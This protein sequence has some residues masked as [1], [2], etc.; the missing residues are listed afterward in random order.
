MGAALH[1]LIIVFIVC[2]MQ[3]SVGQSHSI[4]YCQMMS[5]KRGNLMLN[6]NGASTPEE[7]GGGG[8]GA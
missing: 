8:L 7:K 4:K 3:R 2:K 1:S 6:R 5:Y